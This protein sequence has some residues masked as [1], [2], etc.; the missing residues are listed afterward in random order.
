LLQFYFELK[1]KT[2]II[3]TGSSA[4]VEGSVLQALLVLVIKMVPGM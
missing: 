4:E 2:K 3:F 1:Y